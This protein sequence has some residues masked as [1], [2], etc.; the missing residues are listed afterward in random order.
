MLNFVVDI[1]VDT[2]KLDRAFIKSCTSGDRGGLFLKRLV[3]MIKS[4]GYHVICEG[5]E[6]EEQSE[7][8]R[9]AGCE[10]GQGFLFYEPL[11]MEEYEKMLYEK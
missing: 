5:V 2:V 10:E 3:G 4:L 8:L 9:A 7:A 11:P 6:T 1:P